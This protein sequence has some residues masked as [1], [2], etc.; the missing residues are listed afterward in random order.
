MVCDWLLDSYQRLRA[1]ICFTVR[2]CN[3]QW[4]REW[5]S[6]TYLPQ[7]SSCDTVRG[8]RCLDLGASRTVEVQHTPCL[9][10]F[11]S[12]VPRFSHVSPILKC[13]HWLPVE[14]RIIFKILLL[15]YKFLTTGKP[16]YFAPHLSLYTSAVNTR[17]S[18]P[19]KDVS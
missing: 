12:G 15:I 7:A 1:Q 8:Y 11:V 19:E 5:H 10:R 14:Q 6:N 2:L 9:A 13:L 3:I 18:N 17:R 16:K 4:G